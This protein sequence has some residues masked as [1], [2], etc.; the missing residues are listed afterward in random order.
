MGFVAASQKFDADGEM[1][2]VLALDYIDP[3]RDALFRSGRERLC[4]LSSTTER[5]K[6]GA[7]IECS[8]GI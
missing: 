3:R 1:V 8:L 4:Y 6:G 5:W 7:D 2:S